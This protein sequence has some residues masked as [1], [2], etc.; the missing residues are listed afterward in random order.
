MAVRLLRRNAFA[1]APNTSV[2]LCFPGEE[3]QGGEWRSGDGGGKYRRKMRAVQRRKQGF[4][5]VF[6]F[7]GGVLH[8][9]GEI[10]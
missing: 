10:D 2:V 3:G 7:E 5:F 4:M 1:D 9:V 6:F 8:T